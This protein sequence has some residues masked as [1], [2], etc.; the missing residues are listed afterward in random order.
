MQSNA[1]LL[2]PRAAVLLVA[3]LA[4]ACANFPGW[5]RVLAPEVTVMNVAPAQLE[6][7]ESSARVDLRLSNPNEFP[8]AIDGLRF[9]LEINGRRFARGQT[10]QVVELPRLGDARVSVTVHSGLGD[11]LRQIPNMPNGL[12]EMSYRVSGDVFLT[13]PYD[14]VLPFGSEAVEFGAQR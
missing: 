2:A 14:R 3:A 6:G 10:D 4:L 13:S 1:V 11:V 7:F 9:Q 8:L 5:G 12:E